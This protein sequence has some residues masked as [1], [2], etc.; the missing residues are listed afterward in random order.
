[1]I[2]LILALCLFAAVELA[3]SEKMLKMLEEAGVES[4][5][6]QQDP[7]ASSHRDN[8]KL[9]DISADNNT[10]RQSGDSYPTNCYSSSAHAP[11][12]ALKVVRDAI[13][14]YSDALKSANYIV[15]NLDSVNGA[16]AVWHGLGGSTWA[17]F[18]GNYWCVDYKGYEIWMS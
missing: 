5:S 9:Q 6:S 16:I 2:K 14:L 13:H 11:A 10:E 17:A 12:N 8:K 7:D 18:R 4:D 1:M 15:D 3:S